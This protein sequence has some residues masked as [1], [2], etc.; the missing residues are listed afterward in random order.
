[1]PRTLSD[2]TISHFLGLSLFEE[3]NFDMI[4][5]LENEKKKNMASEE[6][7]KYKS[8]VSNLFTLN[9]EVFLY[10]EYTSRWWC[11][12]HTY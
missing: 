3:Y 11:T 2:A 12:L 5:I 8:N 9:R 6:I 7:I 4:I 10:Q 1:M